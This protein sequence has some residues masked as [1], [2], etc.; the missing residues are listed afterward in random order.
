MARKLSECELPPGGT[1]LSSSQFGFINN[2]P[3]VG[4]SVHVNQTEIS[5]RIFQS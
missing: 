1:V 5:W 4:K 2:I 3:S